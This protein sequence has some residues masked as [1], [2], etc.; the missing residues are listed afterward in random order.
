[1]TVEQEQG[2]TVVSSAF[3]TTRQ[4]VDPPEGQN[5]R[6]QDADLGKFTVTGGLGRVAGRSYELTVLLDL[7]HISSSEKL[8]GEKPTGFLN[9][10]A[11]RK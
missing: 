4:R 7:L 11:L 5:L 3:S 9:K 10:M 8:S 2:C 1:M 6:L